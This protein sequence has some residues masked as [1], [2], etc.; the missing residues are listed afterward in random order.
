M[1][2]TAKNRLSITLA[3]VLSVMPMVR[4]VV[5]PAVQIAGTPTAAIVF[6][7]VVGAAAMLG[8]DAVSKASSISISP[9]SA[10]V[11]VPYAGTITYSGGYAGE[12]AS[13]DIGGVCLG[14]TTLAPGLSVTYHSGNSAN[15]TG[16]PTGSP[17]TVSITAT[18][19]DGSL[20]SGGLNDTR[21]TSLIIQNS[22]GGPV[23]PS[24][25]V[26]PQN[27][28]APVGSDVI[29]SGGA[30]GNPT[31]AYHWTQGI[32]PIPGAISNTFLLSSAQLTNSGIYYLWASNSQGQVS[33][34]CYLTMAITPGTNSLSFEHTNYVLAGQPV[35]MYSWITNVTSGSSNTYLWQYGSGNIPGGTNPDLTLTASQTTPAKSGT[36]SVVLSS[37]VSGTLIVNG[38]TYP[39]FWAFGY[40]PTL[41]QQ[42]TNQTLSPGANAKFAFT[43]AGGNYASIFLYQNQTIVAETNLASYNP[44]LGS[45]TTNISFTISNATLADSGTYTVVVTNFWGSTS[46]SNIT[47]TVGS[48]LSVSAPGGQTNYAG[49]NV[50]LSVTP[51]GT[52]PFGYQWQ[53]GGVSLANGGEFSGVFTNILNIAPAATTDSGNYQV[54]V[55]NNFGSV[56]SSVAV[57]SIVPVPRFALALGTSGVS[58]NAANGVA[59]SEYIVQVSTNL[60][61]AG[62][63]T[64]IFTNNV[65]SSGSIT[66]TN[67]APLNG[68]TFYRVE[69]P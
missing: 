10:T 67:P 31:P 50:S 8:F 59:G 49:K 58:L 18:V 28:I 65:P 57:V 21:S 7:W 17:G 45:A 4:S 52:S 62:G 12:M 16:T 34:Y 42:P 41:S 33:S 24:M 22:G 39:S 66:F 44:S 64:P 47:L 19:T 30:S 43:V 40:P 26:T 35:T 69:F 20:C 14:S 55:T 15:V 11:G 2:T 25:L 1:N 23:V 3:G 54:V 51:S 13:M 37:Y 27:V 36:Y 68:D 63:W 6:R 32:T 29:L 9:P 60:A 5:V 53:K 61:D 38:Q 46:S 56:T 48:P